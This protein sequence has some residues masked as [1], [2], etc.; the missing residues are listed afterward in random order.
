MDNGQSAFN[1]F[2]GQGLAPHQAAG[3]VGNLQGES[4]QGLN[5]NAVNPGDGRDGSDSIGIGQ[6][7][8]GRAQALKDYAASK[9]TA[10]NDLPTQLE[11]M[12]SELKGPESAAYSG[13]LAAK[14]P[15]QAGQAML[16]YERPADWNK[17]GAHPERAQYAARA[18]QAYGGG[19]P[20]MAP[21]AAPGSP[22]FAQPQQAAPQAQPAAPSTQRLQFGGGGGGG[23]FQQPAPAMQAPPIFAS[24]R[25]PVDLAGL[26][27]AFP[28][29]NFFAKG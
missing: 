3:I 25:R 22:M 5:P 10:W 7:N 26:R 13:L 6:W 16:A 23:A 27:A 15:E 29:Q 19:Q 18:M 11:F 1:F 17:P 12:H 28:A 2:T 14:T 9:G 4:G 24:P 20:A 8:G 21:P